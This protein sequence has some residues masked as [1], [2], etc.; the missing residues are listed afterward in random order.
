MVNTDHDLFRQIAIGDEAAFG[1][2]FR[3]YDRRIY[4]FV[5]KM[6]KSEVLAEEITQEI[7]IKIWKTRERLPSIDQPEAYIFTIAARHTLDQI[8]KKLNENRMLQRLSTTLYP[9][10]NDPEEMLLFKDKEALVQQ[11]VDQ[12]TPQQKAVYT[13]SRQ[14]GLSYEEI[15]QKLGIS[16]NTVRNHLVKALQSMRDWLEQQDHIPVILIACAHILLHSGKN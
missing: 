11:A 4:P 12:L 6:I 2:L 9:V 16:P 10:H 7:F 5:L 14:Q 13:L 15:G 8:K 3:R 1:E